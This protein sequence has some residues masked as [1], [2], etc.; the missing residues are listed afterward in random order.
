VV[1]TV[2]AIFPFG[3]AEVAALLLLRVRRLLPR[4]PCGMR[5]IPAVTSVGPELQRHPGRRNIKSRPTATGLLDAA[6]ADNAVSSDSGQTD[7]SPKRAA[8]AH[9]TGT[10]S[11]RGTGDRPRTRRRPS[12]S[13]S[14]RGRIADNLTHPGKTTVA[15][16]VRLRSGSVHH[17][18]G[19][20]QGADCPSPVD[21]DCFLTSGRQPGA[22]NLKARGEPRN[23]GEGR[24][25]A[26][27]RASCPAFTNRGYP[28]GSPGELHGE[29]GCS[30]FQVVSYF[31]FLGRNEDPR[32][33]APGLAGR[34]TAFLARFLVGEPG[35]VDDR[36][37]RDAMHA[38]CGAGSLVFGFLS[39]DG[40]A[41][42][43]R[44]TGPI[45]TRPPRSSRL[46]VRE[47]GPP[48]RDECGCAGGHSGSIRPVMGTSS[49][50]GRELD[51]RPVTLV[52]PAR[53]S[54]VG[55]LG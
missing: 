8:R 34:R 42:R 14:R 47:V 39:G 3:P 21:A 12:R 25:R 46:L 43:R 45:R 38:S 18:G 17:R 22:C 10:W 23:C 2:A 50:G 11:G 9:E 30:H 27:G 37:W 29:V 41:T 52:G 35:S 31:V 51:R 36:E 6:A 28:L 33:S 4:R 15:L 54:D 13:R 19:G 20:V 49:R 40:L 53:A 32:P 16:W 24:G 55:E 26:G 7:A 1:G 48:V 44:S 5:G